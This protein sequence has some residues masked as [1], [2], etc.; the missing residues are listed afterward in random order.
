MLSFTATKLL[1]LLVYPLSH[2][3]LLLLLALI[4]LRLGCARR[5]FYI[6]LLGVGWLYICSTSWFGGL[7]MGHLERDFVPRAMSVV[8]EAD[9]IV[10]L[11]GAVRGDTHMGTRA[12]LNSRADRLVH[13][14]DLYRRGKAPVILLTG[15]AITGERPE[16]EQMKDVLLVMGVPA[17]DMLLERV[18]RNTNDNAVYTAQMLRARDL[19]RVL[20]VT[21]AYHMRRALGVF[22]AQGVEAVPA[23]T[24]Y[25]RLVARSLLPGWLPGV[26]N[27][28][29]TSYALHEIVGYWVY[30][31]RGWL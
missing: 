9:A 30:R 28:T 2:S 4:F 10:L 1:A 15:G 23:P 18:S 8:E 5:G 11:G 31:W 26:G 24:D 3:L 20:L 17:R 7:L 12:D 22:R 21:S 16:A 29:S 27:L 6:A 25:Q 14:V 13:A 19:R